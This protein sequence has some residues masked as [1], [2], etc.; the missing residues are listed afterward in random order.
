MLN[1]LHVVDS[2]P[3]FVL[4]SLEAEEARLV[5]EHLAGCTICRKE[6]EAY[7]MVADRLLLGLPEAAPPMELKTRLMEN[8][9]RLNRRPAPQQ[10]GWRLPR[11]LL[12]VGAFASLFLIVLL[13]VSNVMLWGK[14]ARAEVLLRGPLGMRAIA[15]QN[16]TAAVGASGFVIISA[17]GRNGVLVVDQL[18]ALDETQAYQIWL[19][20]DS[21]PTSG[22]VF[23]VDESGY[24][25]LRIIAPDSLISYSEIRVT[26]EPGGGSANPTGAEVLN[27]SLFNP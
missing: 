19:M 25:G 6:L 20:R 15:L 2:V 1:D 3:A 8:I 10:A 21:Q 9:Q 24:R 16:T 13:V 22:A 18:P 4:G 14:V 17:D 12:P 5:A 27:G 7:Q 23:S 11:R 26:I